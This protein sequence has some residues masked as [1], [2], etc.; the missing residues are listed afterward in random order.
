MNNTTEGHLIKFIIYIG[1]N[2]SKTFKDGKDGFLIAVYF[3]PVD[4]LF[5]IQA[6]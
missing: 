4:I 1:R 5:L 6:T 3:A 2:I